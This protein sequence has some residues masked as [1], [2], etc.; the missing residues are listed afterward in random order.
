M[1]PYKIK[2]FAQVCIYNLKMRIITLRG[3]VKADNV[4]SAKYPGIRGDSWGCGNPKFGCHLVGTHLLVVTAERATAGGWPPQFYI[5]LYT[6][7]I[8][9]VIYSRG[10]I[11]N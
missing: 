8:N 10:T 11:I 1:H 2:G 3:L 7:L 5:F 4:M 6:P 9:I